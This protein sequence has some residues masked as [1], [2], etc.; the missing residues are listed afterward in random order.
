VEEL[1]TTNEELQSTNEE[2][3]TTNEELQSTN[4]ELETMNEELQSMNDELQAMNEELRDRTTA[5]NDVNGYFDSVLTSLQAG[6]VVVDAELR[7]RTWNRQAEELWGLRGDEVAGQHLLNLDIG[8]PADEIRPLV[9]AAL[10]DGSDPHRADIAARNRRG[11]EITVRLT[12]TA[13]RG[14]ADEPRGVV[15]VMND[16]S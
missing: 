14:T 10:A 1:E 9:R 5:L 2:L 8:L 7:V 13:M 15:L 11:R 12:C 16:L 3:E 6:V 4:E